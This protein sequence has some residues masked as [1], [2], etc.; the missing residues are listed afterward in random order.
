MSSLIFFFSFQKSTVLSQRPAW[1]GG[2]DIQAPTIAEDILPGR[3]I[4]TN[5]VVIPGR[6]FRLKHRKKAQW[7]ILKFYFSKWKSLLQI[8]NF[9]D[10][11][12]IIIAVSFVLD[13]DSIGVSGSGSRQSKMVPKKEKLRNYEDLFV[14]GLRAFSGTLTFF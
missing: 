11:G 6:I 3:R 12:R 7:G 14:G 8:R 9:D 13:P 10:G 4:L 1:D 5:N 2:A